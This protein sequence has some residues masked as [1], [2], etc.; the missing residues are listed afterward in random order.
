VVTGRR[1][2]GLVAQAWRVCG[3]AGACPEW[4]ACGRFIRK[5]DNLSH[6]HA[7]RLTGRC[8]GASV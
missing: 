2:R 8:P 3:E 6:A 1:A 4:H 5:T 7:G